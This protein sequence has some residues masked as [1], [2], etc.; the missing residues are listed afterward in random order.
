MVFLRSGRWVKCSCTFIAH[1]SASVFVCIVL[2][3][4]LGCGLSWSLCVG[5]CVCACVCVWVCVCVCVCG[6]LF[7]PAIISRS[8]ESWLL[9]VLVGVS[10]CFRVCVCVWLVV[11][12]L[13]LLTLHMHPLTH[14]TLSTAAIVAIA[15]IT[16][17]HTLTITL[18]YTFIHTLTLHYTF[19]LTI[20]LTGLCCQHTFSPCF[21]SLWA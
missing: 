6:A 4:A 17:A 11:L 14:H 9:R 21:L 5:V 2:V 13:L 12:A 16:F 20:T 10:K 3:S 18:H 8:G 15:L 7:S 1:S 19:T